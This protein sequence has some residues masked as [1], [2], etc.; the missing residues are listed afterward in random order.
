MKTLDTIQE[1]H[2]IFSTAG[3][4]PALVTCSD[5]Q[6]WICKYDRD[7]MSLFNELL[8]S[9]YARLWN[10]KTPD[11]CFIK[12]KDEHIKSPLQKNLFNKE[13]FG[14]LYLKNAYEINLTAMPLFQDKVFLSKIKNK[15]DFLK[16][17]LFDIWLSNEDRSHNNFNLL[18]D[19]YN[20]AYFFY[21]IDHV[22]IFNTKSGLN[23]GMEII[24]EEETI[25]NTDL[26][27]ILFR[28]KNIRKLTDEIIQNFYLCTEKCESELER[29]VGN[30]PESWNL[31]IVEIKSKIKNS[32]FDSN[33]LKRCEDK[34]REYIN[35]YI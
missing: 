6:D 17:A 15:E 7:P 9:E 22:N 33:W 30:V 3:S 2:K 31:N 25:I 32:I 28:K 13:C 12:V 8:A 5:M 16:I 10:I 26:A 24:T 21:V 35:L 23:Y 14:S 29:I 1:I 19:S 34:F 11:I 18:I 4:K 27:K 20:N